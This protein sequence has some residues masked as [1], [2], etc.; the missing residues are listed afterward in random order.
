MP[1]GS[2]QGLLAHMVVDGE[3]LEMIASH[4][5]TTVPAIL[6]V[7]YNFRLPVWAQYPIVIPVGAND[8]IG[9]PALEVYVVG[10]TYENISAESLSGILGVDEAALEF[11]NV[12]SGNCKF[13]K[14]DVLLIP[15]S[16]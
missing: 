9:L 15:R 12:C 5:Q 13:H 1:L 6:A 7:N 14:R 2:N 8:A 11:Y 4:Y 16:Q 3:A 10:E